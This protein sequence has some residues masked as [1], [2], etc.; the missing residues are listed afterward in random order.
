MGRPLP[1]GDVVEEV[2]VVGGAGRDE[3]RREECRVQEL[4]TSSRTAVQVGGQKGREGRGES[5]VRESGVRRK[6]RGK[7]TKKIEAS[8]LEK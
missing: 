2:A 3:T 4:K 1:A 5:G 8:D 7:R 6:E